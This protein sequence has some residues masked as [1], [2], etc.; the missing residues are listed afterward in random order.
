M[1]YPDWQRLGDLRGNPQYRA[2]NGLLV[3]R[4]LVTADDQHRCLVLDGSDDSFPIVHDGFHD[5]LAAAQSDAA[6]F[7]EGWNRIH[8]AAR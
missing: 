4:T 3:A 8:H 7:M 1:Q 2:T 6:L 5:T